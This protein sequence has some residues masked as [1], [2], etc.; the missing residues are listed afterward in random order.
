MIIILILL[1][2]LL[3]LAV[4]ILVSGFI[5]GFRLVPQNWHF[6]IS[7]FGKYHK[8]W[9]AGL[10]WFFPWI[11][12][13]IDGK[14]Y[15]GE[16][17]MD[18]AL[19]DPQALGG[20]VVDFINESSPVKVKLHY[21]FTD[22]YKA[23]YNADYPLRILENLTDGLVRSFLSHYTISEA[24]KLK[25][26]FN[27]EV[28]ASGT[29][30]ELGDNNRPK[31][32]SLKKEL[33]NTDYFLALQDIGITPLRLIIVDIELTDV[34][35][36][37]RS[38]ILQADTDL[39]VAEREIKIEEKRKES[40][41]VRAGAKKE[42]I[43]IIADGEAEALERLGAAMLSQV[44][45]L[46]GPLGAPQAAKHIQELRKFEAMEK[47]GNLTWI[48][49]SKDSQRGAELG[50]GLSSSQAKKGGDND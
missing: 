30:I 44:N 40:A 22:A 1:Y 50:A 25:S 24:N 11:I 41:I 37:E 42:E 10:H 26:S 38:R 47:S 3:L 34:I 45:D 21:K 46:V 17:S 4:F 43:T 19:G 29:V 36:R 7:R 13:R 5:A 9:V 6:V 14:V 15:M 39:K 16:Q 32:T 23:L 49:G 12:F 18:L 8:T 35:L 20:G 28:L 27:L 48:E 33:V 31:E 2:V